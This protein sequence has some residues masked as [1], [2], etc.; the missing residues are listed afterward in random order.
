MKMKRINKIA[1]TIAA[2]TSPKT[3][4]TDTANIR[5]KPLRATQPQIGGVNFS[6]NSNWFMR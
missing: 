4:L 5:Q 3:A 2:I 1:K 6:R